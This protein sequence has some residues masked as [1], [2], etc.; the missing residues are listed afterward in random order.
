MGETAEKALM[1]MK[2]KH[3]VSLLDMVED[4]NRTATLHP[5]EQWKE[6]IGDNITY[7][8]LL[9]VLACERHWGGEGKG[10]GEL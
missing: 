5:I 7:L 9:W 8:Y 10:K 2:V 4:L 1:G 3:D 6:K